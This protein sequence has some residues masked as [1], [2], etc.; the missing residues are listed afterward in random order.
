MKRIISLYLLTIALVSCEK[1]DPMAMPDDVWVDLGLSVM[2]A[3][4][5]IGAQTPEEYGCYYAFGETEEKDTYTWD[6]YLHYTMNENGEW[7]GPLHDL[8]VSRRHLAGTEFDVAHVTWGNGAVMPTSDEFQEL[9]SK[10]TRRD[11]IYNGVK[12]NKFTGPNGNSI[13]LPFCGAHNEDGFTGAEEYGYYWS[14]KVKTS[15]VAGYVE[16]GGA[17]LQGNFI[18]FG[19][20]FCM[21]F[22]VRPVKYK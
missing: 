1:V 4:C 18:N 14:S 13:F 10:C 7:E 8:L 21:G 15:G 2:W 5:N 17:W 6:N 16:Y 20:D 11:A 12:G 3:K 22:A 19:L 9:F